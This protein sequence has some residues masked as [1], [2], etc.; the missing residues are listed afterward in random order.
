MTATLAFAQTKPR[1]RD[2]GVPFD[3]TPGPNNA[4]TDVNG[5]EVGHTTLIS[6]SGKLKVGE[7]PVRTGVTADSSPRRRFANDSVFGAWFTLNGNGEMTGTTWLEDSGFLDGPIMITNTHSVGVVRDA[8]IAWKVKRGEPDMEGYWWSLPVVAETWDGY[9]NDINGFHVNP[10]TSSTRSIPRTAARRRRQRRRR[11]RHDLQRIQGRDR[12]CLAR[13]RCRQQAATPSACSCSA[14]TD[15]A[16]SSAS[17]AFPSARK[18]PITPFCDED[19]GSI[20]IVVATDAP[21]IP[22]Q[23]KRLA[24]RASLGLGRDGS[25]SGDGS[26]DIFVP[27]PPPIPGAASTKESAT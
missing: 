22:T 15:G 11:H 8:V 12:H 21:L 17:P 18:F 5:V 2:L 23:L 13:A 7:G 1:A 26:G 14:T 20:I 6:G 4:I 27:S 16:T 9:L 3:G 10:S 25:F 19:V 24:R